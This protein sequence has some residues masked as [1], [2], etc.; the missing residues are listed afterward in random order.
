MS[1]SPLGGNP[2]R[3]LRYDFSRVNTFMLSDINGRPHLDRMRVGTA[4]QDAKQDCMVCDTDGVWT[5]TTCAGKRLCDV[6]V[7]TLKS[8]TGH[9]IVRTE[10][11]WF[12]ASDPAVACSACRLCPIG[13]PH[14]R[15][16]VCPDY[17]LCASCEDINQVCRPYGGE[18]MVHDVKHPLIKYRTLEQLAE[19]TA[20]ARATA[21]PPAASVPVFNLFDND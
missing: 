15:C 3:P 18:L 20:A 11:A 10:G 21:A 16:S 2:P 4:A 14:Y 6:C 7:R 5:C 12:H 13:F 9:A 1:A 19:A 17:V 8:H